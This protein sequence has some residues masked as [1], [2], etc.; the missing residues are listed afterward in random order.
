MVSSQSVDQFLLKLKR[1]QVAGST[2]TATE[3]ANLLRTVIS[4]SRWANAKALL[5]LISEI[6]KDLVEAQP[7]E[8]SVGNV[9]RRILRLVRE[10]YKG[11]YASNSR[12]TEQRISMHNIPS[13]ESVRTTSDD[14]HSSESSSK[15]FSV[16]SDSS[17]YNLLAMAEQPETDY[18]KQLFSLKQS[19]IQSVNEL[20][21]EL[22]NVENV[23]SSQAL[24]Y[25]DSGDI[26]LTVGRST[27][28][29]QFLLHAASKRCYFV[30][31]VA[32]SSVAA[33]GKALYNRL[34]NCNVQVHCIPDSSIFAV[35]SK[36]NKVIIGCHAVTANGGI[37]ARGGTLLAAVAAKH[38][39]VPVCVVTG[40]Y[41]VTPI[42]PENHEDFNLYTSPHQIIPFAE[43]LGCQSNIKLINPLFDHVDS[44]LVNL[45]ITN[46]G[47]HPPSYVYRLLGELYDQDDFDLVNHA[48]G[49]LHIK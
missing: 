44:T 34:K 8:F 6:T 38:F 48:F 26:I 10:E 47:T 25:I 30:I 15:H 14:G 16:V 46:V 24:E 20:I 33:S 1:R 45:F 39:S 28:V 35:M 9:C 23:I 41:K 4:N 2:Q 32:E 36:V 27:T 12:G 29:E 3:T 5:Q 7:V 31:Y 21:D 42:Y 22:E 18:S 17:M 13:N 49:H 40:M 43:G 19:I 37:I 11:I